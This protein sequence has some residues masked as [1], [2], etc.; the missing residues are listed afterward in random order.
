MK[1]PIPIP[2]APKGETKPSTPVPKTRAKAG[3]YVAF[4]CDYLASPRALKAHG[5]GRGHTGHK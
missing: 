1:E 2:S 4:V 5:C 3:K